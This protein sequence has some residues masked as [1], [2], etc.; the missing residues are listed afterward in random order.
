MQNTVERPTMLG[1][2]G[3][4]HFDHAQCAECGIQHRHQLHDT[5]SVSNSTNEYGLLGNICCDRAFLNC[6]GKR[7]KWLYFTLQSALPNAPK[8]QKSSLSCQTDIY[9]SPTLF[10]ALN[11]RILKRVTTDCCFF[12]AGNNSHTFSIH[13]CPSGFSHLSAWRVS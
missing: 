8:G 13:C 5:Q 11:L 3:P 4:A 2:Q 12:R 1:W 10:K 6:N 7:N 9:K